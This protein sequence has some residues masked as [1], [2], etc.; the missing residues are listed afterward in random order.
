[1][2]NIPSNNN[3]SSLPTSVVLSLIPLILY[4]LQQQKLTLLLKKKKEEW[5]VIIQKTKMKTKN[6]FFKKKK[7]STRNITATSNSCSHSSPSSLEMSTTRKLIPAATS[8]K[9]NDTNGHLLIIDGCNGPLRII[10]TTTSSKTTTTT[11]TSAKDEE[12]NKDYKNYNDHSSSSSSLGL[13]F[14]SS[15]WLFFSS[16]ISWFLR[17]KQK[18]NKSGHASS[19]SDVHHHSCLSSSTT[20]TTT[21]IS[22]ISFLHMIHDNHYKHNPQ[23]SNKS[24]NKRI[25]LLPKLDILLEK[26]LP[27]LDSAYIYFDGKGLKSSMQD[28]VWWYNSNSQCNCSRIKVQVT[29]CQD[30]VDD[31]IIDLIS[32][33]DEER[34]NHPRQESNDLVGPTLLDEPNGNGTDVMVLDDFLKDIEQ[35]RM[36]MSQ[37][38]D[39]SCL[40]RGMHVYTISRNDQGPGRHRNILK[41]MCWMRPHSPY[42]FFQPFPLWTSSWSLT[43]SMPLSKDWSFLKDVKMRKMDQLFGRSVKKDSI[44]MMDPDEGVGMTGKDGMQKIKKNCVGRKSIV[45]TDDVFLR[46]RVVQAGG[47][48]MTFEQLWYLLDGLD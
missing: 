48:V 46:Q 43:L 44:V 25:D 18:K 30:E 8:A 31:V 10:T 36:M 5:S 34:K 1:M 45:V 47:F 35:C 33:C 17:S 2:Y 12:K 9:K 16:F 23:T 4:L 28:Q 32:S 27:F 38:E 40:P 19:P 15:M 22:S 21:N 37:K 39:P 42:C 14:S 26:H 7:S 20:N 11:T 24:N 6:F 41:P 29:N 13:F 3:S